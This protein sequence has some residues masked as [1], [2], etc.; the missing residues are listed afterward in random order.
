MENIIASLKKFYYN[1]TKKNEDGNLV[2][3]EWEDQ[4]MGKDGCKRLAKCWKDY[5]ND[6]E[7]LRE[8]LQYKQ[9]SSGR[10]SKEEQDLIRETSVKQNKFLEKCLST[11]DLDAEFN[12]IDDPID[13]E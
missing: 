2:N 12:L 3:S 5:G 10:Y 13:I 1:K 4:V 8:I 11:H 7:Y 6:L 9:I